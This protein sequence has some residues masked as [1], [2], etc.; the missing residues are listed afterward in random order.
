MDWSQSAG[1]MR[2]LGLAILLVAAAWSTAAAQG[3]TGSLSGIVTDESK[4][5]L[6]GATVTVKQTETGQTRSLVTDDQGRYRAEALAPGQYSLTVE[7]TGFSTAEFDKLTLTVG[8][9]AALNVEMKVGGVTERVV[10]T[11]EAPLLQTHESSVTALVDQKQIRELPLNGRDFSQLTLLQLGV[12]ASPTTSETVDRG[13]GTQVSIAGS[14]PNQISYQ[15]DGTDANT[16]GNGSPGS[17]AGGLLGVDTVREFQV[18]VNNYSAEYGRSTG[19]VV[20][21]ITRSGTNDF[22][23][24]AFEFTR[25]SAFDFPPYAPYGKQWEALAAASEVANAAAFPPARQARQYPRSQVPV[26]AR[27]F[28]GGYVYS[29]WN[30]ARGLANTVI[31]GALYTHLRGDDAESVERLLDV[32]HLAHSLRQDP[33]LVGQLVGIGVDATGL[34]PGADVLAVA[35]EEVEALRV[36]DEVDGLGQ[37]DQHQAAVVDEHA[38]RFVGRSR[39]VAALAEHPGGTDDIRDRR[40]APLESPDEADDSEVGRRRGPNHIVSLVPR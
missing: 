17:A 29:G 14:R 28:P 10:V 38:D 22:H 20:T 33:T 23:G 3:T 15:L 9:D 25:N 31:D 8:Q 21:A 24:G 12:T 6:P 32:L 36:A 19:G 39:N 35:A 5:A 4:G 30:G 7:L 13:M 26:S 1:R 2:A 18:L 27:Q 11:S 16:Q 37:V 34:E 40:G